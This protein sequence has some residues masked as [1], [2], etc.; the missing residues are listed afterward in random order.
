MLTSF[1]FAQLSTTQLVERTRVRLQELLK[2]TAMV[3][4]L[5]EF[6]QDSQLFREVSNLSKS[7][8][9]NPTM[10]KNVNSPKTLTNDQYFSA[11]GC[12]NDFAQY[13]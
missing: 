10:L 5:L 1:D 4:L 9:I 7:A 12:A 11:R 13:K 8:G 2:P 6:T 3:N